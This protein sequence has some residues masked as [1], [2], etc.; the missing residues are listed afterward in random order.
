MVFSNRA[1]AFAKPTARQAVLVLVLE[2]RGGGTNAT[3]GTHATY[4]SSAFVLLS[5]T[6]L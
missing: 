5:G 3:Y 1:P 2:V 4:G 6:S